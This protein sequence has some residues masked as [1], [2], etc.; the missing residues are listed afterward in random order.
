MTR[1]ASLAAF[2]V[3]LGL[4]SAGPAHAATVTL[5]STDRAEHCEGTDC[6]PASRD[7]ELAMSTAAG[8]T[9]DAGVSADAHGYTVRLTGAPLLAGTGCAIVTP[10]DVRCAVALTSRNCHG[11]AADANPACNVTA[12]ATLTG[13]DG[14]D[15]LR[16]D[17]SSAASAFTLDGGAGDD[18]LSVAAVPRSYPSAVVRGGPGDDVLLGGAGDDELY[19]GAGSDTLIG[20]PGDDLLDGDGDGNGDAETSVDADVLNG[21]PGTD[22]ASWQGATQPVVVDLADPGT[23]GRAGEGDRLISIENVLGGSG[24]DTLLGDAGPN[25]LDS[26][27]GTGDV[28][29]GRGGNDT[30]S[31]EGTAIGGSGND[32]LPP[33][34]TSECGAGGLDMIDTNNLDDAPLPALNSSCEFA[35]PYSEGYSLRPQR[36][37]GGRV[38]VRVLLRPSP[39][40]YRHVLS[41]TLRAQTGGPVLANGSRMLSPVHRLTV[42]ALDMKLTTTGR[43]LVKPGLAARLRTGD[44]LSF[45]VRMR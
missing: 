31:T 18:H 45:P 39:F 41:L 32:L 13:G 4:L 14:P 16:V 38:A 23:D 25:D 1:K 29:D 30:L 19:G 5:R 36:I 15:Q 17:S 21:G 9:V 28:V 3:A 22:T 7:V 26:G 11:G 24:N 34:A 10:G 44:E 33:L 12:G 8:E 6:A 2:A 42:L 20:G 40:S 43:R 35:G 37:S 27:G